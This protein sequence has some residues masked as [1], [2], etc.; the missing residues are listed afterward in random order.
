MKVHVFKLPAHNNDE[1]RVQSQRLRHSLNNALLRYHA[2]E[3]L[4]AHFSD[5]HPREFLGEDCL[6]LEGG[7]WACGMNV[8]ILDDVVIRGGTINFRCYFEDFD[9]LRDM[10]E[11]ML[12]EKDDKSYGVVGYI[13]FDAIGCLTVQ[14][15]VLDEPAK[16]DVLP[17]WTSDLTGDGDLGFSAH[18]LDN[19]AFYGTI[20]R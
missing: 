19:G 1:R 5:A 17:S 4:G 6:V 18:L 7:P 13:G 10:K 16:D 3:V 8:Y 11:P 15:L 9:P 20:E 12:P 14:L 2:R